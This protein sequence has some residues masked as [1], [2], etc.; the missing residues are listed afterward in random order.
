MNKL[1][2]SILAVSFLAGFTGAAMAETAT[3]N[4]QVT[5]TVSA[6]CSATTTDLAFGTYNPISG[7]NKDS[8][9]GAVSVTCTNGTA[10]NIALDAGANPSAP[11]DVTTRRMKGDQPTPS[12]LSYQIYLD[13]AGGTV[14]GDGT[15]GVLNP[16]NSTFFTGTGSAQSHTAYGRIPVSV[17]NT[18]APE[19][20]Y[21]DT[22]H[23]TVTTN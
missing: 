10:Y 15:S 14:W 22:V 18:A 17:G 1:S 9:A 6:A 21:T 11:G 13:S 4:L 3:A 5:A 8:S 16:S 2:A 23:V 19:G 20:A 7:A 12:Y